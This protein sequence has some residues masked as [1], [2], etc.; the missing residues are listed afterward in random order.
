MQGFL[1]W[2]ADAFGDFLDGFLG[3]LIDWAISFFGN[4]A[5]G[6]KKVFDAFF[7]IFD[8]V[9]TLLK[10]LDR[11][12]KAVFWFFPPVAFNI[13]YLGL[14]LVFLFLLFKLLMKKQRGGLN[15]GR[16]CGFS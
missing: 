6:L 7:S 5:D 12:M 14:G 13:L 11:M 1:K 10:F 15:Y 16:Y 2:V 8:F 4:L 3:G 9:P